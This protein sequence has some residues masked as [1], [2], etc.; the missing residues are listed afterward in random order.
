MQIMVW[1]TFRLYVSCIKTENLGIRTRC[2]WWWLVL[3]AIYWRLIEG[4]SKLIKYTV[5]IR[6]HSTRQKVKTACLCLYNYAHDKNWFVH[7]R[8]TRAI[9]FRSSGMWHCV[10]WFVFFDCLMIAV[11]S[12]PRIKYTE[13]DYQLQR[14]GSSFTTLLNL[15]KKKKLNFHAS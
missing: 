5:M 14:Q 3:I 6:K 13:K 4:Y 10:I 15:T 12:I 8:A 11:P 9:G 7:H 2:P 1:A